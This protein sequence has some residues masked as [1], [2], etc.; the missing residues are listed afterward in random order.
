VRLLVLSRD[1][2]APAAAARLLTEQGYGASEITVFEHLGGTAERRLGGTA[3][4]WNH[5]RPA[6][7]NTMAILC[8]PGAGWRA[9]PPLPGLPDDAFVSD[10]QLTKRETRAITPAALAPLPG[11]VLWDGGAGSGSI[12]IEWL[13]AVRPVRVA[14]G[15]EARAFAIERNA[16]RC[17]MIEANAARLGT[18][19]LAI[20]EGAAPEMLAELPPPDSVFVGGGVTLAGLLEVCWEALPEGGRLVANAVSLEAAARL[21]EFRADNGGTLTR[22]AVARAEP[23]GGLTAFRPLMEVTQYVAVKGAGGR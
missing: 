1:G 23:V 22:L 15:G 3:A 6:D 20:V 9:L 4:A 16:D 11:Q 8:R 12:A 14:G 7:L 10:G 13:R 19:Q 5:P 17:R 18:P 21:L 2:E